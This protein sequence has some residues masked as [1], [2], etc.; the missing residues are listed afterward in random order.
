MKKIYLV[1]LL[2]L[3]GVALAGCDDFLDDNR[4]PQDTQI[5]NPTFWSNAVNVQNQVNTFYEDFTGF[6][7]EVGN[8][9]WNTLS[10]DQ[11]GYPGAG[12]Q[13]W[14]FV[15]V[16]PSSTLWNS[17]YEEIRRAN[18]I[19]SGV[20]GSS[21]TDSE[22]ENFIGI[23][24]MM[25]GYEF[26]MLVRAFGD[27][28]LVTKALDPADDAE[29]YGPRTPRNQVMDYAL[30]DLEYAAQNI[31]AESSKTTF[32]KD[33]AKAIM[34]EVCLFEGTFAK[35]H[36]NDDARMKRYLEKA[37]ATADE[38]LAKYP[39]GNDYRALYNS[40]AADLEANQEV[41]FMKAYEQGILMHSTI[42]WTSSSTAVCGITRDAFDAYLFTDG[43]PLAT[44]TLDKND[45]AVMDADGNLSLAAPLAV[46]DKRLSETIYPYVMYSGQAYKGPNTMAMTSTTGY[47]IQKYNNFEIPYDDATNS[48][49]NYTSAPLYWGAEIA[50]AYA[51]AKAELGTLTDAD[52][53][54]S[55][56]KLYQRAGLP[57]QTKAG[58]E[59][60]NDPAKNMTG[61]SSLIWEIRRCRRCELIMDQDTRYWDLIR[62]H[63]LQL[64]D[65]SKNP[66]IVQGANLVNATAPIDKIGNYMD[67]SFHSS[68]TFSDR[69]YF[70]PIPSG[71]RALNPKLT[72]NDGWK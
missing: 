43:K 20:E 64:L 52:I 11:A 21:L 35:Y 60:I 38:L 12:F 57:D 36:A 27:V 7:S 30:D 71:Q 41:I 18:L 49:R 8:F 13:T 50:L 61:V 29:L 53:A 48:Y 56:N 39:V 62:W 6:G 54:K 69:E 65:T 14:K 44:T 66:T 33:L 10:D 34:T 24:R 17:A 58:L 15:N 46:R 2:T 23:S 25:R 9:Y 37:A 22:K 26:Y 42:N 63:Q 3:G 67:A 4:Y 19:I 70:Y 1:G 59:A 5:V 55:L 40:F 31:G 72:Q 45:A 28:P 16:P 47:G 51:E 32:S 68:R